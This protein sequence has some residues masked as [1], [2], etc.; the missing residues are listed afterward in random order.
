MAAISL[1]VST[2]YGSTIDVSRVEHE[3]M[4]IEIN[5][6]LNPCR[7]GWEPIPAHRDWVM[8]HGTIADIRLLVQKM[9]AALP[10]E[11][12]QEAV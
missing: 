8:I 11:P 10:A 9:L 12:T 1:S 4:S 2:S 3:A 5:T 7:P 6:N